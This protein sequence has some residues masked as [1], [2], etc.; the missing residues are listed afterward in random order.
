MGL[1]L[2]AKL[3]FFEAHSYS[4]CRCVYDIHSLFLCFFL[5][6]CYGVWLV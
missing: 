3:C 6:C 1:M 5:L 4:G 2:N